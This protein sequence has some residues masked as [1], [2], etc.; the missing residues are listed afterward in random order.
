VFLPDSETCR[1][2]EAKQ[3]SEVLTDFLQIKIRENVKT[4][5]HQP[6]SLPPLPDFLIQFRTG[7]SSNT[8]NLLFLFII[9]TL[10]HKSKYHA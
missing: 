5:T 3:I 8:P 7:K 2:K 4:K 6:L 10:A 1:Q 9:F